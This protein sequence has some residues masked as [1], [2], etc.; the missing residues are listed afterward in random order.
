[1]VQC[2]ER[3]PRTC[4]E[5]GH[6]LPQASGNPECD[7]QSRTCAPTLCCPARIWTRFSDSADGLHGGMWF[8]LPISQLWSPREGFLTSH[9][10]IY[11]I[12]KLWE[13]HIVYLR[14][15]L[16]TEKD[17]FWITEKRSILC[18]LTVSCF[19]YSASSSCPICHWWLRNTDMCN[20]RKLGLRNRT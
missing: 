16:E 6:L 18:L 5:P 12:N 10:E 3:G 17:C 11:L 15:Q 9:F 20:N 1:M 19:Y 14:D 7:L 8:V 4:Q 2:C 13:D